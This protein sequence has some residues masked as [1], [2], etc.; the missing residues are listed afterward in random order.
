MVGRSLQLVFTG[1]SRSIVPGLEEDRG[2]ES[3]ADE[4]STSKKS[5]EDV[6][7]C[8]RHVFLL[9]IAPPQVADSVFQSC[10]TVCT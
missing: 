3:G 5:V 7:T 2:E 6:E 8:C 10:G 4:A 1:K 9:L